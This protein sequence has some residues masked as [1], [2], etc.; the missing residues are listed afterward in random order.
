MMQKSR[1]RWQLYLFCKGISH[2]FDSNKHE[3]KL[4]QQSQ[5]Q[6]VPA[7]TP[8]AVSPPL[9]LASIPQGKSSPPLAIP[10]TRWYQR[11]QV[12]TWH[13]P[14]I[15]DHR[16]EYP[17]PVCSYCTGTC[18]KHQHVSWNF[19]WICDIRTEILPNF[20]SILM[21]KVGIN[22][23][24]SLEDAHVSGASG[25]AIWFGEHL[26]AAAK[27]FDPKAFA[28]HCEVINLAKA[29]MW[30]PMELINEDVW[31]ISFARWPRVLYLTVV[32]NQQP[33]S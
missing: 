23:L 21:H 2:I 24:S 8:F 10:Q 17:P 12:L 13:E 29:V 1:P 15:L 33:M 18:L 11:Y 28:I 4:T 32:L 6:P 25:K 14:T 31:C 5:D 27:I 22:S 19:L 20:M 7:N 3:R 9:A 16:L 26:F 30:K